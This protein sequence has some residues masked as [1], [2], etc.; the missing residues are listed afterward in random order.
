VQTLPNCL[1]LLKSPP[2]KH[3]RPFN[4]AIQGIVDQTTEPLI[5][6]CP[7]LKKKAYQKER[8]TNV[9]QASPAST[10]TGMNLP[11]Y[12]GLPGQ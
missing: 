8:K 4:I 9:Q 12:V 7:T 11:R 5:N 2:S 1:Q 3:F 6:Q 10:M